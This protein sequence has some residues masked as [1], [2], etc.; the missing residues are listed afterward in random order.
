[1]AMLL[2]S[3]MGVFLLCY[4]VIA[5]AQEEKKWDLSGYVKDMVSVNIPEDADSVL[6]DNLIHN[7][8]NF[9][10]KPTEKLRTQIDL[11][12]RLFTGDL[13]QAIPNYSEFVDVNNDYFDL[14]VVPVDERKVV[15][16]SIIDRA[17]IEWQEETWTLTVG[18]QRI[19]W[20]VTMVWNPNDIFNAY[21]FF[22]F[23][24]EERPGSDAIRFQR[25]IGYAGGF[26]LAIKAADSWDEFTAA[27]LYKWNTGSY[28]LQVLAGYM[29][30][31]W[32][33][34]GGWAGNIGLAGFKGEFTY[35]RSTTDE[36]PDEFLGAISFDYSF[37][38]SLYFN[39]STLYNSAAGSTENLFLL[40]GS[41]ANFDVR[42]LSPYAW[43]T[44]I[45][46]SYPVTPLL[47][48]AMSVMYF[49]DQ[50]GVFLSPSITYSIVQNLD[51]DFIGQLYP[52]AQPTGV[53]ILYGRLKYSF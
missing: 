15:L 29:R 16:H 26:E 25:Y 20:G 22:D 45:T 21:N 1:M 43:S 41:S 50:P 30:Q 11:R 40:Q 5:V 2:R 33:G 23:D 12:T 38:N 44:F 52:N 46:G 32:V 10:W 36:Q 34:G 8:L 37:A 17:Y 7:R 14:S 13:V 27:G 39:L 4:T 28:D 42:S 3:A 9:S 35:F 24:Y 18:R 47:N 49:P 31:N 48:V 19:N 53:N 51:F 6:V